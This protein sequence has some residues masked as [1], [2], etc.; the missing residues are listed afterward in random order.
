VD[1]REMTVA[2]EHA[3]PYGIAAGPDGAVT[4]HDLPAPKSEPHGL[5]VGPAGNL[6]VALEIGRVAVLERSRA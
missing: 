5:A 1:I 3:G 2:D 6:W 4:E